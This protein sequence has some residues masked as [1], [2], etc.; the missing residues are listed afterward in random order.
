LT[1]N[2]AETG[3]DS[4]T[5]LGSVDVTNLIHGWSTQAPL[6]SA[7]TAAIDSN[8]VFETSANSNKWTFQLTLTEEASIPTTLTGMTINGVDYTSQLTTLFGSTAIGPGN[9]ITAAVTLQNVAIPKTVV[10]TFTGVD[11]SGAKWTTGMSIPFSGQQPQ[12]TISGMSNAAS[13]KQ[14]YAPGMILSVYGTGMGSWVQSANNLPLPDFLAG[15][16]ATVNGV[17]APIYYVSP[18]QVNLQIPYE[19][20]TGQAT[21]TLGNPYVDV[22][23]KFQVVSAAPGIF[24]FSD[25]TLNPF[26]TAKRGQTITLYITGEG[27]VTPAV[28]T[29][30]APSSRSVPTPVQALAVSI[31]GVAASAPLPFVGI[32][33]GLVGVTQVNFTIPASAPL[34]PQPVVVTVGTAT[35]PPATVNITQ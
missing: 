29:G 30:M 13:G 8:P 34:G 24:T 35:S 3:Y 2:S 19:T 28:A 33:S 10:L 1:G 32:P 25:G 14:A 20:R 16:E 5:G 4:A 12:L 22:N 17:P 7:V 11:S 18:T 26:P 31:G 15:F 9:S 23:Y 27:A 21:L 6:A